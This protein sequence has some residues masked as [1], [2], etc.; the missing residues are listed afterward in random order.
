MLVLRTSNFHGA[1]IRPIVPRHKRSIEYR[2]DDVT[3]IYFFDIMVY[4]AIF[5]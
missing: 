1:T 5:L 4:D 3:K 2:S